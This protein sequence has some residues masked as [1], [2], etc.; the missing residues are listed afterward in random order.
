MTTLD[1]LADLTG[2][3]CLA[4]IFLLSGIS[5]LGQ[6][7]STQSYMAAS[8]VPEALLPLVILLEVIGGLAIILGWQT[9]IAALLLAGF[10]VAAG[11][12][13]HAN[14]HDQVQMIM[15]LKNIAIAGGLLVVFVR[16]AGPWSLDARRY[17]SP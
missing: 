4:A 7:T 15:F 2:R 17:E 1:K 9:R 14:F 3:S 13:F 11:L 5:K 10:T 6:Y 12:L 16:G 8:G